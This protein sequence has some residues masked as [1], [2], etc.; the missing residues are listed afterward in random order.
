MRIKS[1]Q[2]RKV[3]FTR[4]RQGGLHPPPS[5]V[6]FPLRFSATEEDT[7]LPLDALE[8]LRRRDSGDVFSFSVSASVAK[9]L[10]KHTSWLRESDLARVV[11][12]VVPIIRYSVICRFATGED[13]DKWFGA[14]ESLRRRGS[15][16]V[17]VYSESASVAKRQRETC[18]SLSL[19]LC[20]SAG[21]GR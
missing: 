13:T 6:R 9:L 4:R 17:F 19:P 20:G 12:S 11:K 16:D 10:A 8:R 7:D 18:F 14:S 21:L 5:S 1:Y 2:A 3:V 15:S